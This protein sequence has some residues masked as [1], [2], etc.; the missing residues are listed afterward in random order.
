MLNMLNMLNMINLNYLCL[1]VG[2]VAPSIT[3]I[4]VYVSGYLFDQ[5][6]TCLAICASD[7]KYAHQV[8]IINNKYYLLKQYIEKRILY[9]KKYSMGIFLFDGHIL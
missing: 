5:F 1:V 6:M 2:L 3:I 9:K 4:G 8:F 7:N